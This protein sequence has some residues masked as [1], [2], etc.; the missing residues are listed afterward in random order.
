M[1]SLFLL[2]KRKPNQVKNNYINR[3]KSLKIIE[4]YILQNGPTTYMEFVMNVN[5]SLG[6]LYTYNHKGY[7]ET[8]LIKS[9]KQN[10]RERLI[11]GIN[12]QNVKLLPKD[13]KDRNKKLE[14]I[15]MIIERN[16]PQTLRQL[17]RAVCDK[18]TIRYWMKVGLL[19][20]RKDG[21]IVMI[22]GINSGELL[23]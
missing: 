4:V 14:K 17:G 9:D 5:F 7:L 22:T 16:G 8:K 10:G 19:K 13:D 20:G 2:M 3:V 12:W 23:T 15:G 1:S 6:T 11:L 18:E 21:N